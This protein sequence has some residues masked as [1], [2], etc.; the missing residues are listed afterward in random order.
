MAADH[1]AGTTPEDAAGAGLEPVMLSALEHYSYC[2]RSCALIHIE[3][4]FTDNVYTVRGQQAH[5][6][7]DDPGDELRAGVVREYGLPLWSERLGLIGRGDLVE[8]TLDGPYPVEYKSGKKRQWGHETIQ[9]C[10]QALCLEEMTGQPVTRGAV[11]YR[12]SRARREVVFDAALRQLVAETAAA[13]RAMLAGGV[14]PPPIDDA[15][16]THCSLIDTCLPAAPAALAGLA[17]SGPPDWLAA[18][19]DTGPGPER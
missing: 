10:A 4:T 19:F 17:E 13:V 12:A 11:Y 16:C 5:E 8:F 15:R 3:Q 6:R 14:L 7:V 18:L 1:N 9:L 2:P